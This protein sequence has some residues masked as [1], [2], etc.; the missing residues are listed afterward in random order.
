MAVC[1]GGGGLV[2]AGLLHHAG[3]EM[4]HEVGQHGAARVAGRLALSFNR[5]FGLRH[6]GHAW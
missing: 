4:R 6:R 2:V 5:G 3:G 1:A